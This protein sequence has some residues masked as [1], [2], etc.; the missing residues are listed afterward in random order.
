ME[1]KSLKRVHPPSFKARVAIEAIKGE[2]TLAELTSIYG[3]HHS[4]IIKWKQ[5]VLAG[6]ENIFSEKR[7]LKEEDD[8]ELTSELYRQIGRLKV[9]VDFLKKK[10]GIFEGRQ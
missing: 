5:A 3:V 8:R 6:I 10:M 9:E 7:K 4:M 2:K 1:N